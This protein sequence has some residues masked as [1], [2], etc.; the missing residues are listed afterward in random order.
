MQLQMT[1]FEPK[2][3]HE[4]IFG[5]A[6][7]LTFEKG[8]FEAYS[9]INKFHTSNQ[10]SFEI[11]V[12]HNGDILNEKCKVTF[13]GIEPTRKREIKQ[14][15]TLVEIER[16]SDLEDHIES[17]ING[18]INGNYKFS[19]E[20]LELTDHLEQLNKQRLIDKALDAGDKEKFI[21]LVNS[22]EGSK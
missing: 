5:S 16:L 15:L 3:F 8:D 12:N 14:P 6:Y 17:F 2:L 21:S 9:L 11:A 18:K 4:D 7:I 13:I 20:T 10:N 19:N 22:L 1:K